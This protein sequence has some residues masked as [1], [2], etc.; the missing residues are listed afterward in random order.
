MLEVY[1]NY[2]VLLLYAIL[3]LRALP[4]NVRGVAIPSSREKPRGTRL[5]LRLYFVYRRDL[6]ARVRTRSKLVQA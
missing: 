6:W 3:V 5:A 2:L 1:I 4:S